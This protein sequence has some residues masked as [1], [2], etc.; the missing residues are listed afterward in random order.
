[1]SYS[2]EI[3][4]LIDAGV[5]K[6]NEN[7]DSKEVVEKFQELFEHMERSADANAVSLAKALGVVRQESKTLVLDELKESPESFR[8]ALK[9][10]ANSFTKH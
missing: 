6:V 7:Q 4:D 3:Q 5:L 8:D 10:I 1:M 9:T 2:K